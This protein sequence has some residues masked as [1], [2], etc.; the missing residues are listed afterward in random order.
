MQQ[1]T[2]ACYEALQAGQSVMVVGENKLWRNNV[3]MNLEQLGMPYQKP[4]EEPFCK[5]LESTEAGKRIT[6][7]KLHALA[8]NP[9]RVAPWRSLLALGD[10][11]GRSVAFELLRERALKQDKAVDTALR[12]L[13]AAQER[14]EGTQKPVEDSFGPG[15]LQLVQA[16]REALCLLEQ[17][18][19]EVRL[20]KSSTPAQ[21]NTPAQANIL[22]CSAQEALDRQ[23]DVVIFGCFVNGIIPCRAYFDAAGLVGTQK[24]RE[25]QRC[26]QAVNSVLGSARKRLL[27]TGFKTAPLEYAERLGLK[28]ERI[29]LKNGVRMCQLSE[30]IFLPHK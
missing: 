3:C 23:A 6:R 13:A 21:N 28:I 27:L 11:T 16:Y 7:A 25:K 19:N 15:A 17:E 14:A 4:N 29:K 20:A 5:T 22:V 2:F 8:Q 10:Y 1:L 18:K 9:C 24:Q 30:S 26:Q 12:D